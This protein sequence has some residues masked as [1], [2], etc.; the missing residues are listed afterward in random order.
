M[1]TPTP[2]TLSTLSTVLGF[3][4]IEFWTPDDNNDLRCLHFYLSESVKIVVKRIFPEEVN[5]SPG[6][7]DSWR[8]NSLRVRSPLPSLSLSSPH[9]HFVSFVKKQEWQKMVIF[10]ATQV[11]GIY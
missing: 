5:F 11:I 2:Q 8:M 6:M 7:S 3:D 9:L 4:V 1:M 10:G